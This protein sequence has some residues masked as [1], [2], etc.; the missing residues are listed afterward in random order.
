MSHRRQVRRRAGVA[1]AVAGSLAG[2]GILAAPALARH[3]GDTCP[4][5]TLCEWRDINF[6]L[7]VQWWNPNGSDNSYTDNFYSSAASA[8]LNDTISS[9]WNN[10]NR[11]VKLC[12]SANCRYGWRGNG[13]VDSEAGLVLPPGTAVA[14]LRGYY[15]FY[16]GF[17]NDSISAHR[18][19]ASR[20]AIEGY[21]ASQQGCSL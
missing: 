21:E 18:T 6:N 20:P 14:D 19:Y 9:V 3:P 11:W 16:N 7:P 2:P 1:V 4:G 13:N 15:G 8:G 12:Q 5:N 17:Y 10:S